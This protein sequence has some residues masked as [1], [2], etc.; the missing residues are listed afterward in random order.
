MRF[1]TEDDPVRYLS[2]LQ[3][4]APRFEPSDAT[5]AA[6]RML[7]DQPRQGTADLGMHHDAALDLV[8]SDLDDLA[9][10]QNTTRAWA[11][12]GRS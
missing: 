10:Q 9:A 6:A 4:S 3:R 8:T 5:L 12:A 1:A 2:I 7:L 11:T